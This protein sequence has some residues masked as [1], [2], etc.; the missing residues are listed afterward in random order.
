LGLGFPSLL[1]RIFQAEDVKH[2]LH[3]GQDLR[4]VAVY[5]ALGGLVIQQLGKLALGH[6]QV[7][8]V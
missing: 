1:N 4:L 3:I 6:Q 7:E 2:Q 8:Q 5:V